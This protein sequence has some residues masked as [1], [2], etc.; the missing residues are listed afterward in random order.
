MM[1]LISATGVLRD[2]LQRS[3]VDDR[4]ESA[5]SLAP[6]RAPAAPRPP[7]A[8]VTLAATSSLS[9]VMRSEPSEPPFKRGAA[10]SDMI[11]SN[12]CYSQFRSAQSHRPLTTSLD[13]RAPGRAPDN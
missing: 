10:S 13:E 1:E 9:A 3:D 7:P 11:V 4:V 8:P 5:L 2:K 12:L 6:S